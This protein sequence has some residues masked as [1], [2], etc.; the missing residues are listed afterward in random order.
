MTSPEAPRLARQ[1]GLVLRWGVVASTAC[2]GVGMLL[3]LVGAGRVATSLLDTGVIV[4]LATPIARVLV[5][6]VEYTVM[7]D[8]P[9]VT[10][11]AIVLV[12]LMAGVVAALLF[13]RKL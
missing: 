10:L 8:W 5:S 4:L 9:F 2:Q 11:T 7:R 1:I 3:S 12:E 13:N 6:M